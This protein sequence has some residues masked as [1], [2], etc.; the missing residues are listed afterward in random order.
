MKNSIEIATAWPPVTVKSVLFAT[1]LPVRSKSAFAH[2]HAVA[3][4]FGATLTLYHAA[5]ADPPGASD[6]PWSKRRA[7]LEA[8]LAG[9][10]GD[11]DVKRRTIVEAATSPHR[12]LVRRIHEMQPDLTVIATH[13]GELGHLFLGSVAEKVVQHG[14]R[15]ILSV[16]GDGPGDEPYRRVLVATPWPHLSEVALNWSRSFGTTFGSE[17]LVLHVGDEPTEADLWQACD[18]ALAGTDWSARVESGRVWHRIV[19]AAAV[20]SSDLVIL[21]ARSL[22][23]AEGGL[24]SGITERVVRHAP[25]SVLAV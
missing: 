4:A 20:E 19:E 23:S 11:T 10:T 12:E 17:V 22:R 24:V 3:A 13:G 1:D 6:P 5:V 25:C 9:L 21:A 18:P 14:G 16:R 8:A 2:A 15:A 7:G